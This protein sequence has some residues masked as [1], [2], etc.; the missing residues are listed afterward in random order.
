MYYNKNKTLIIFISFLWMQAFFYACNNPG[1]IQADSITLQHETAI[2]DSASIKEVAKKKEKLLTFE[3]CLEGK[4]IPP[5][6]IDSLSLIEVEYFGFDSLFHT[7]QLVVHSRFGGDVQEI[8]KQVAKI[9]F[10]IEK[11]RPVV[12]YKWSDSLSMA[13]N[14]TSCFNYR[15][16]AFAR[17]LSLHAYGRAIDI[18]PRQNPYFNPITKKNEPENAEY[19]PKA[20]GTVTYNSKVLK[21]F[22]DHGWHWGG[23]WPKNKDYQ[24]FYR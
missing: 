22:L 20:P 2:L 10:P 21:I 6:I 14:N 18:N 7:G 4:E 9:K 24:H 1:R 13:D 16:V 23:H 11:I 8:F 5:T 12:L 15:E 17:R 19:K 3:Q